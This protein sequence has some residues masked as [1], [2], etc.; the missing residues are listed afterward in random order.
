MADTHLGYRAFRETTPAGSANQRSHDFEEAW[1]AAVTA[2]IVEQPDLCVHAGDVFHYA[3]PGWREVRAF[4]AGLRRLVKAGIPTVVIGGNHDTPRLRSEASVFTA[5]AAMIP[6][7]NF[8]C[9]YQLAT[10]P[11]P[12]LNAVVQC[13]PFGA[14]EP[15]TEIPIPAI[16]STYNLLVI[17]GGV[18]SADGNDPWKF[19]AKHS[20]I[21]IHYKAQAYDYVALG[22]HHDCYSPAPKAWYSGPTERCGFS[23]ETGATGWALV[24]VLGRGEHPRVTHKDVAARPM[25]TLLGGRFLDC[26]GLK[27]EDIA[28]AAA[29]LVEQANLPDGILR[30]KVEEIGRGELRA[31]QRLLDQSVKG[32]CWKAIIAPVSEAVGA[33][34][35]EE[36]QQSTGLGLSDLFKEF[37]ASR[38][39]DDPTFADRFL[40]RGLEA[41]STAEAASKEESD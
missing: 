13:V 14:L 21:D 39:Y 19:S 40:A 25:K 3:R 35:N 24:E 5:M 17:H 30:I 4:G 15:N 23:D 33:D 12:G 20:V 37:V 27:S 22:H 31:T 36:R 32:K 7:V 1:Q 18:Y 9:G 34:W 41:I 16:A 8:V 28:R 6:E 2:V 29:E 10:I 11:L 38:T 26:R